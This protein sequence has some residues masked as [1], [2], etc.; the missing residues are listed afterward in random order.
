MKVYDITEAKHINQTPLKVFDIADRI[1]LLTKIGNLPG[2]DDNS[3]PQLAWLYGRLGAWLESYK[4]VKNAV[5]HPPS[6]TTLNKMLVI[7][8]K[9]YDQIQ[10]FESKRLNNK[11]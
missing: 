6:P 11:Q 4:L 8:E 7:I 10:D 2:P 3:E 1:G 9:V 5:T